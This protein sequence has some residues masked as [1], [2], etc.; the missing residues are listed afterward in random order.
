MLCIPHASNMYST[1]LWLDSWHPSGIL[2]EV[3]G[4]KVV[5]DAHNRLEAKLSSIILNGARFWRPVRSEALVEIQARLHEVR[6]GPYDK[7]V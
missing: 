2:I 3:F 7:L 1:F 6:F 4:C 5:Y